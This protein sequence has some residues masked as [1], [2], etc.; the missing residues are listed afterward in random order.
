[1]MTSTTKLMLNMEDTNTDDQVSLAGTHE[2]AGPY[3]RSDGRNE[4]HTTGVQDNGHVI[5][6]ISREE[7][8]MHDRAT[9]FK[10]PSFMPQ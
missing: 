1:M 6:N 9:K 5:E 3:N 2:Q 7:R 10:W 4:Q 8:V